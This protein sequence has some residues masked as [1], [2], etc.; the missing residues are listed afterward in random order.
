MTP[1]SDDRGIQSEGVYLRPVST[2]IIPFPR[3]VG[4]LR[5]Q[6]GIITQGKID[7]ENFF[8]PKGAYFDI[9]RME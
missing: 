4:G 5:F 7:V 9:V 8:R 6:R 3:K 2:F 1:L